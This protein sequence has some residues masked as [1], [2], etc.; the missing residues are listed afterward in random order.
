MFYGLRISG[1][2]EDSNTRL[3]VEKNVQVIE[4]N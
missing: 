1:T 4:L 3:N 2:Q